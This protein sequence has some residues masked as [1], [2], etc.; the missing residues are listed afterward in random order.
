MLPLLVSMLIM[1]SMI[2]ISAAALFTSTHSL[3]TK[4]KSDEYVFEIKMVKKSV[5]ALSM[6]VTETQDDITTTYAALPVGTP[7]GNI[8]LLPDQIMKKKNVYNRDILYCPFGA[9]VSNTFTATVNGGPTV[10]YGIE[11]RQLTKNNRT[12]DYVIGTAD[13]NFSKNGILGVII[14]PN[15]LSQAPLNCNGLIYSNETQSFTIDGGRVETITA[16]EIE[17]V[18]LQL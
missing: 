17:A 15:Y 10:S 1:L 5:L 16:L 11:T 9:K 14:S 3:A 8:N 4:V 18:N 6:T 2:G 7:S 13:N 12:L